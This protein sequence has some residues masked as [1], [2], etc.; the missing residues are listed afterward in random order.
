MN[1]HDRRILH[2]TGKD[3]W[4]TPQP[5]FDA[6][7]ELFHFNFDAA[8]HGENTKCDQFLT[9]GQDALTYPWRGRVW[10]NPPYSR[11]VGMWVRRARNE[12]QQN[13]D[14]ELVCCLLYARTDTKWWHQD[15]MPHAS[16]VFF[17]CGRVTFVG[18][19]AP[20]PAPSVVVVFRPKTPR[21]GPVFQ[22]MAVPR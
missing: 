16:E 7:N 6:L 22:A 9:L 13:P 12:A 15:V 3:D 18:A 1:A 4:E 17:L 5:L 20:A 11:E 2:S 14:V 19:P 8:A 21:G 10:L